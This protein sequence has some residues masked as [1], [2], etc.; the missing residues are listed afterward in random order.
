[1]RKKVADDLPA[2]SVDRILLVEKAEEF[3]SLA[4]ERKGLNDKKKAV[5]EL[6]NAAFPQ[7]K[8][9][10]A[11]LIG[12]KAKMAV[13]FGEEYEEK[14]LNNKSEEQATFMLELKESMYC[15]K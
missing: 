1:M 3:R 4:M 15:Y 5:V 8:E 6:F 11:L 13:I 10:L 14:Y 2:K 7:L 9:M 12:A